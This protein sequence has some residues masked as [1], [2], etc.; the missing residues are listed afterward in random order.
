M[1]IKS[2]G[3]ITKGIDKQISKI[4]GNIN[5][6]ELQKRA[7]LGSAHILRSVLSMK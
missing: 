1:I 2:L 3:V 6:T 4:T 7:L 5:V